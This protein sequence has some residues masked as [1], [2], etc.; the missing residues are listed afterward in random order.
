MKDWEIEH[1]LEE[2]IPLIRNPYKRRS[3]LQ[4]LI[5]EMEERKKNEN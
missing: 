1:D 2:N 4:R 3:K 5:E